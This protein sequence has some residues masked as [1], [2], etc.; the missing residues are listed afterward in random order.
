MQILCFL[1]G[2]CHLESSC[3]LLVVSDH[4]QH[5]NGRSVRM[6]IVKFT[7]NNFE[8]Q[9]PTEYLAVKWKSTFLNI[10]R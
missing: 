1:G 7:M 3:V 10:W 4:L 5:E 9:I 2:K 8:N 6:P